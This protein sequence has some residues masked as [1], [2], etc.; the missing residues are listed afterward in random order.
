MM[1]VDFRNT[2]SAGDV[3]RIVRDVETEAHR[4]WPQLMRL[5]IRPLHDAVAEGQKAEL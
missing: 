5:F 4:Q 3:E 2:I 1:N